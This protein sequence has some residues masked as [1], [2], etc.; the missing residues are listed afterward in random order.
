MYFQN[1]LRIIKEK[2]CSSISTNNISTDFY[3]YYEVLTIVITYKHNLFHFNI[4]HWNN[5]I[6]NKKVTCTLSE[7]KHTCELNEDTNYEMEEFFIVY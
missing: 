2:C 7:N 5:V 4:I 3:F 6:R 1:I